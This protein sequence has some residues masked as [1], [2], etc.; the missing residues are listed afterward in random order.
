MGG[1]LGFRSFKPTPLLNLFIPLHTRFSGPY[2]CWEVCQRVAC[3]GGWCCILRFIELLRVQVHWCP[4][5]TFIGFNSDPDR[6]EEGWFRER[7]VKGPSGFSWLFR[8]L[9]TRTHRGGG[10]SLKLERNIRTCKAAHAYPSSPDLVSLPP[11]F[12]S[13]H[14]SPG[15][16][17]ALQVDLLFGRPSAPEVVGKAP[18]SE[19]LWTRRK[20][21]ELDPVALP[22]FLNP[23]G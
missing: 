3:P 1:R 4:H 16:Q 8:C 13:C 17:L 14:P 2:S 22:V 21:G 20:W 9:P 10:R 11:P 7:S 15:E 6:D 23:G 19:S 12:P 5:S 18:E